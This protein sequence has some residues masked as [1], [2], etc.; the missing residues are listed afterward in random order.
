MFT[1]KNSILLVIDVQGNLAHK[2]H[3]KE[4]LFRHIKAL[5]NAAHILKIPIIYT[6]QVPEK[7]GS[8]VV[9]IAEHLKEVVYFDKVSFSCCGN[10]QFSA[11]LKK[12]KRKQIIVCGIETHVCVY[13]TVADLL[14]ADYEVQIVADAVSS[15]AAD[16]KHWAIERMKQDGALLTGTEMIITELLKTSAH[17]KF[18]EI[19]NLIK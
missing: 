17:P 19:L 11:E 4:I 3:E 18:R 15:R 14:A 12:L 16:N 7:I 10:P 5:I 6:E 9:E 2:M 13:Q 8:T 1:I